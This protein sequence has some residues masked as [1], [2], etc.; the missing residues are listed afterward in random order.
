MSSQ[1]NKSK[2]SAED[3]VA[4]T[5]PATVCYNLLILFES[6]TWVLIFISIKRFIIVFQP[7]AKL[8]IH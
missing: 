8:Q 1:V 5:Y 4:E 7:I 2:A 6:G 3:V